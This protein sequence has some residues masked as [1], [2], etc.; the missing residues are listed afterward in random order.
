MCI[1]TEAEKAF[2]KNQHSVIKTSKKLGKEGPFLNTI[3]AVYSKFRVNLILNR[4]NLKAQH[5]YFH[6]T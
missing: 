3:K 1:L 5:H 4:K 2:D 6:S